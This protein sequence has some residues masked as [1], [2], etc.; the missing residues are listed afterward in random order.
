MQRLLLSLA[1]VSALGLAS[2]DVYMHSMRGPNNRLNEQNV[3]RN[4]NNRLWDSQ[5]NNKGGYSIG[6]DDDDYEV[7]RPPSRHQK[8]WRLGRERRPPLSYI[9]HAKTTST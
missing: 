5:N 3:N 8:P 4:N 9:R 6:I 7:S 1:L 2:A